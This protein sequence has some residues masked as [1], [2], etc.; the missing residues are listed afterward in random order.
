[1]GHL[2]ILAGH[3]DMSRGET[4][5]ELWKAA[6]KIPERESAMNGRE[7]A[8]RALRGIYALELCYLCPPARRERCLLGPAQQLGLE[9]VLLSQLREEILA[10]K[11]EGREPLSF[12]L[13]SPTRIVREANKLSHIRQRSKRVKSFL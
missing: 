6:W 2:Q 7:E 12:L 5:K 1:M 4:G 10:A 11:L 3:D 13:C 9:R 8:T